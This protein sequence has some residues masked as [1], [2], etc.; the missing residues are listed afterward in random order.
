MLTGLCTGVSS[1]IE[2]EDSPTPISWQLHGGEEWS[3]KGYLGAARR[4]GEKP[5]AV[6]VTMNSLSTFLTELP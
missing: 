5:S 3:L 4:G 2:S 1:G 6:W